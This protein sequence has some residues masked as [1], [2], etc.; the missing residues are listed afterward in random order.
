MSYPTLYEP[1]FEHDACGVGFIADK[2]GRRTRATLERGIEAL[3]N[4]AHRGALDADARTG[5]GAGF[6]TQIPHKLFLRE[7]GKLGYS[8]DDP[9]RLA[10]GV[11]FLPAA[12]G[13]RAAAEELAVRALTG[14]GVE[15]LG[16]R[17]VP[18]DMDVL[19]TKARSTLP[20]MRHLLVLRPEGVGKDEFRR[21]LYL[22]RKKI[23]AEADARSLEVYVPSLSDRT[24]AYKGLFV[25]EQLSDF[26]HDLRDPLYET[27]IC[28]FHQRYSTNTFPRW[29]IAQPFR[30]LAHNGEINT[31]QGNKNWT[32]AREREFESRLWGERVEEIAPVIQAGG[33]DSAELDNVLELLVLSGR[34]LLHTMAMLVPDAHEGMPDMPEDLKAF[35]EYHATL[36]EPWDGPAALAFTDG[37]VVGATLDRNGLR[38]LRYV[39]TEDGMVFVGSE[40]GIFDIEES[41]VLEKGRLGPGQMLAVDLNRGVFLRDAE[42]KAELAASGPWQEWAGATSHLDRVGA[43]EAPKRGEGFGQRQLAFGVSDDGLDY[44]LKPMAES[45]KEPIFSM[46][47]DTPVAVLSQKVRPLNDYFRQRFAQ[48][49]NPP[50]DHYRESLVMTL[51]MFLGRRGSILEDGADH[52]RVLKIESPILFN[53]DLE[54]LKEV[55]APFECATLDATFEVGGDGAWYERALSRLLADADKAVEEGKSIL[56]LSD[57]NIGPGRANIPI[58]LAVGAVHHHL[59]RERLRMRCSLVCET[60]EAREVHQIATLL[61]YGAS[62]V[63]PYLALATLADLSER[64]EISK[65]YEEAA[66]NYRHALQD[67]LL[68]IMSKMGISTM[69]SYSGA[70]IFEAVGL[71]DEVVERYFTGTPSQI[72]GIGLDEIFQDVMRLHELA[73]AAEVANGAGKLPDSGYY[74]FRKNAEQHAFAPPVFKALHK[75]ARSGE[76]EDYESYAGLVENRQPLA[77]RDLLELHSD[78][79]PIPVEEVEPLA[80]IVSRFVTA[81]MSHGSLSREAHET[82]SIAMNRLGGKSNSGEGGEDHERFKPYPNGDWGNSAIK[83]VASARFGVTPAYLKS[84]RELQIKMAQGS[85]PGEGGQIPGDKVTEEIAELRHATPGYPLISPPPHHDIYSIEDLAQLIFDLKQANPDAWVNVKLVAEA[86]IGTIAAGVAKGYA[87]AIWVSGHDGGTGA[88]PMSSIKHAGSP[89]ELGLAETHQTL[90]LNDLRGRIRLGTDGGLKTGRDVVVAAMLG[91]D[92]Y[93]FGTGVLVAT[94]CVMARQCHLNTCPVGITTQDPR[95]R[96]R[97]KG[98]PENVVRFMVSVAQ[99]VQEILASLGY[100]KIEEVIGRTNLLRVRPDLTHAKHLTVDLSRVLA[101]PDPKDEKARR[102]LQDRNDKAVQPGERLLNL[103]MVHDAAPVLERTEP[104]ELYYD[105]RNTDRTAGATLA[106]EIGAKYGDR[107]LPEGTVRVNFTG[108]AGQ[109]FGAFLAGG[110]SFTLVGEANDYV[111]K[112]MAGGEVAIRLPEGARYDPSENSIVGNTVLYGATGGALYAN[113]RAGERFGVRNSGALAVI[114]GV[115][116]HGCEYMT[117]GLIVV[118]GRTGRNFAAGMTGGSAFVLDEDGHFLDRLNGEFVMAEKVGEQDAETL[119]TLIQRHHKLTSSPKAAWI[120]ENWEENLLRFWKVSMPPKAPVQEDIAMESA[121]LTEP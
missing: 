74:R 60:G 7:A 8:V 90:V 63:N 115:G 121:A 96:A 64:G 99:E 3:R 86:G 41:T 111:C 19:G 106:G 42:I 39:Y 22:A 65:T 118:L 2:H 80:D 6:L 79:E 17:D 66:E 11:F 102:K 68:K 82:I 112:G 110:M 97:F 70:Q 49:T 76:E 9:E 120:L 53:E 56:I 89:W 27:A 100:R 46:G 104:V 45:G 105:I 4:L 37:E 35:Y 54:Q 14:E 116:D 58:L 15:V 5:D 69:A 98:T 119:R 18:V 40:M 77:L 1:R 92:E 23:E 43:V 10:V 38:P 87:D 32:R 21:R 113:G 36:T 78:K 12:E 31:L 28:V 71:N 81:A 109:S 73:Y 67:G 51:E 85:K 30:M 44:V 91:A 48:V 25:S 108:T 52:A 84:A 55:G 20:A 83:Q 114:E 50:I 29:P 94:G 61:G 24:I 13:E 33:S 117:G 72:K 59:I 62:A 26:Y 34:P 16:W 88:S 93:G 57:K 47:D 75:F 107:A 101:D 103:K 95:L